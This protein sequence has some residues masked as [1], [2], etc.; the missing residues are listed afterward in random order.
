[1]ENKELQVIV[2]LCSGVIDRVSLFSDDEKALDYLSKAIGTE[3]KSVEDFTN[4]QEDNEDDYKHE[5]RWFAPTVDQPYID[6]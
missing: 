5:Y 3:F 6:G 1:M 2:E 4:W